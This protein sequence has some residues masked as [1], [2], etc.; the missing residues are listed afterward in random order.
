[1]SECA[2]TNNLVDS[3]MF[4]QKIDAYSNDKRLSIL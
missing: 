2:H 3:A 1:M 4:G